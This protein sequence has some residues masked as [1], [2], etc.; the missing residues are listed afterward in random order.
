MAAGDKVTFKQQVLNSP[1][2]S[3]VKGKRSNHFE[4]LFNETAETYRVARKTDTTICKIIVY[5]IL[6]IY[7]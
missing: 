7:I 5:N 2:K 6:R 3:Y 4:H 1:I